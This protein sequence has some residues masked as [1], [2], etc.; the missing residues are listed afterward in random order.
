MSS[1][2]KAQEGETIGEALPRYS[3]SARKPAAAGKGKPDDVWNIA[4][5]NKLSIGPFDRVT[6]KARAAAKLTRGGT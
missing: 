3:R 1:K 4:A 6:L 5:Q 2:R